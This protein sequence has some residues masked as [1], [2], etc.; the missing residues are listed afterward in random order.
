MKNLSKHHERPIRRVG[1]MSCAD[2]CEYETQR[3]ER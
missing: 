1:K 2:A 3:I